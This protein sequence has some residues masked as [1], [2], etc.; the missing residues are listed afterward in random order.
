MAFIDLIA[1]QRYAF[2]Q[3]RSGAA[4]TA[5]SGRSRTAKSFI[6]LDGCDRAIGREKFLPR[7]KL[8]PPL[9]KKKARKIKVVY[10]LPLQIVFAPSVMI[11]MDV[12]VHGGR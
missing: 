8:A 1:M 6:S 7:E 9:P 3:K 5:H 10:R 4:T 11:F 12:D 2:R